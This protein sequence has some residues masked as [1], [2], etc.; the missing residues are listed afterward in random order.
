MFYWF[1]HATALNLGLSWKTNKVSNY[2]RYYILTELSLDRHFK[3]KTYGLSMFL[4]IV[5]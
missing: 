1:E 4:S 5:T 3:K 2:D